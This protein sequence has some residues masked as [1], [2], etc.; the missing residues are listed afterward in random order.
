MHVKQSKLTKKSIN[1]SLI[2]L[3]IFKKSL[4]IQGGPKAL[5]YAFIFSWGNCPIL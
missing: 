1:R 5:V 2:L 3:A 4:P